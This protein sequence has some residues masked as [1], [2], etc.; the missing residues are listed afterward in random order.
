VIAPDVVWDRIQASGILLDPQSAARLA[1]GWNRHL[2][3]IGR[4]PPLPDEVPGAASFPE[5]AKR[6]VVVN[7]YERN[8]RAR[9]ACIRRYGLD[10]SVCGINFGKHYGDIGEG[11]IHVH[12]LLDLATIGEAYEVDPITDLR[13]VCPNCH[14]MLHTDRP[15]MAIEVLRDK[16]R[17][18]GMKRPT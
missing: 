3:E 15:P 11:F 5:G 8:P 9:E 4:T 7:A 10:C 16:M 18:A 6:Q 12:H 2:E 1:A 13:P 17:A 14:A